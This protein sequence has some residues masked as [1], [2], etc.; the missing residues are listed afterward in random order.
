MKRLFKQLCP[1]IVW[2]AAKWLLPGFTTPA[3]INYQGV[4]THHQ[5]AQMHTGRFGDIYEHY[6][7]LD[8]CRTPD[9]TRLRIYS[10]CLFATI[11]KAL[12]GDFLTAGVSYGIAPRV[13]YE[14]TNFATLGKRLHLIDPFTGVTASGAVEHTYNTNI[15]LVRKQY[16][17]DAPVIFHQALIP[18]CLPL[19]GGEDNWHLFI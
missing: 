6:C 9:V 3:P 14:F 15:E 7:R 4:T 8:P 13:I 2:E 5:M 10:L 19:R 16:P 11:T 1:P 18:D 17:T 12:D